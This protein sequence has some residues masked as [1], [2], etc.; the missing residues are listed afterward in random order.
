MKKACILILVYCLSISLYGLEWPVASPVIFASFAQRNIDILNRGLILEK[1]DI[2]RA[3]GDGV[4]LCTL[5]KKT[6]MSG[7]PGTLGN[8]VILAHEDKLVSVY[9]NLDS[10][11]R[12]KEKKDIENGSILGMTGSSAWGKPLQCIFQ[13]YDSDRKNLLNPLMLLPALPDSKGPVIRNVSAISS[14]GQTIILGSSK[15]LRQ[16]KY[17][18]FA[19]ITD[20]MNASATELA[21][22][23]I[24]I[25]VNGTEMVFLPF[26]L[27]QAE[28]GILMLTSGTSEKELLEDPSRLYLGE[29]QLTRGR[30]DIS[31]LA[32]DFS[33]NERSVLFGLVIE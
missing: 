30:A 24:S 9:G 17:R 27:M 28:N 15:T 29:I 31:I 1:A 32:Q 7:F 26:D 25:L 4:I 6:N 18:I 2:V 20:T 19:D 10:L 23:R 33:G 11:D 13:V 3:S 5:S 22:F 8:A 14:L 16:G 21:P 12:V